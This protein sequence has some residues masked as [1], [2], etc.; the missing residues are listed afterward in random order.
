MAMMDAAKHLCFDALL[1]VLVRFSGLSAG[2]QQSFKESKDF[3][4]NLRFFIQAICAMVI[5]VTE[6]LLSEGCDELSQFAFSSDPWNQQ[7]RLD[8]VFSH[9]EAFGED[10]LLQ[11]QSWFCVPVCRNVFPPQPATCGVVI[12]LTI[13]KRLQSLLEPNFGFLGA[14]CWI[15]SS[16]RVFSLLFTLWP[17]KGDKCDAG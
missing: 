14:C 2:A 17:A 15:H 10:P 4:T 5:C 7:R 9:L 13:R 6:E 8:E 16:L 12:A 3:K 1:D 11:R